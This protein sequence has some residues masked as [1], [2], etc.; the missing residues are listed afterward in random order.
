[1]MFF[2]LQL[3]VLEFMSAVGNTVVDDLNGLIR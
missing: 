3:L 1:M 2:E